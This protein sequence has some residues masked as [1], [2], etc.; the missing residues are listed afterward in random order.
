MVPQ[1]AP[2][3]YVR[4]PATPRVSPPANPP[5]DPTKVFRALAE[6]ERVLGC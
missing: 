3:R 1:P 4:P 6:L 2:V 5:M